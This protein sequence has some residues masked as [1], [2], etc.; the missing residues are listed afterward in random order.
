MVENEW[1]KVLFLGQPVD[2]RQQNH[3]FMD[4]SLSTGGLFWK[5]HRFKDRIHRY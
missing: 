2:N 3:D 1:L 4:G 5:R